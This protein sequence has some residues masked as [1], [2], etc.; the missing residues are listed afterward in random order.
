MVGSYRRLHQNTIHFSP[1]HF[2]QTM[3]HSD[4]P[5]RY[6]FSPSLHWNPQLHQYFLNAYGADHFSRISAALTYAPLF[7]FRYFSLS[8]NMQ[9]HT[10]SSG[11]EHVTTIFDSTNYSTYFS[12]C[13]CLIF[14]EFSNSQPTFP[15]LVHSS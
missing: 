14:I 12:S 5:N 13:N 3:S 8:R 7:I 9:F 2:H 1:T 6:S 11:D 10:N 15:L 4:P